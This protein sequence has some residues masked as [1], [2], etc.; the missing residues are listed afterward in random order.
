VLIV[1]DEA[2]PAVVTKVTIWNHG[3]TVEEVAA[4]RNRSW[5]EWV[6]AH[7][8][9]G[10]TKTSMKGWELYI[11]QE[12]GDTNVSL[13]VGTNRL[14]SDEEITQAAVKGLDAIKPKLDELKKGQHVFVH[15]RRLAAPAPEDQAK[16]V[17]DYCRKIG[18]RVQP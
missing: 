17:A 9:R 3:K 12:G 6:E 11:W 16:A 5:S 18:L 14:K 15:G 8:P 1:D 4:E 7:S 10:R 2:T 13:M